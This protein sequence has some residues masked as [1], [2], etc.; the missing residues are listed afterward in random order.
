MLR[1]PLGQTLFIHLTGREFLPNHDAFDIRRVQRLP[2]QGEEK[3]G[4]NQRRPFIAVDERSPA[5]RQD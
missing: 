1:E 5:W 4:D 2:V 3:F